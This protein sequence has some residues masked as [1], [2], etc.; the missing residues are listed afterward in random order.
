MR[1]IMELQ[2]FDYELKSKPPAL[3]KLFDCLAHVPPCADEPENFTHDLF[4]IEL[5]REW[6][7]QIASY[8][9][10]LKFPLEMSKAQKKRLVTHAQR[11][12][13]IEGELYQKGF[14]GLYCRCVCKEEIPHILKECHDSACGGHFAGRLTALEILRAGYWWPIVFKDSFE[15]CKRCDMCQCATCL[16][17]HLRPNNPIMAALPFEKWGINYVGPLLPTSKHG[18]AYIIVATDYLMKSSEARVVR[19]NDARTIATFLLIM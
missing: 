17:N 10:T 18:K 5:S 7:D 15:W 11:F 6:Y 19:S 12:S 16:E 2:L 13:I 14:E 4:C 3:Q 1:W 8:L 9:S